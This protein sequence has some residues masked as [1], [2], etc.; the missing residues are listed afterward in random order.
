MWPGFELV[1]PPHACP[2]TREAHYVE[3]HREIASL[4]GRTSPHDLPPSTSGARLRRLVGSRA[5][6]HLIA[7]FAG[8]VATGGTGDR[9]SGTAA[10]IH[11]LE[12]ADSNQRRLVGTTWYQY[13]VLS[14]ILRHLHQSLPTRIPHNQ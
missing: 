10:V 8:D 2:L 4:L 14:A 11:W 6:F 3:E 13:E 7:P 9:D 12:L 1:R 5:L